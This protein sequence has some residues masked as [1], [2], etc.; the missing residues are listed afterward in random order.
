MISKLKVAITFLAA[1]IVTTQVPVPEQSP[2]Q[3]PKVKPAV[4]AAVRVTVV[5]L[6]RLAEQKVEGQFM[7]PTSLVTFPPPLTVTPKV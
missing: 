7:P 4:A 1:D 3:P 6:L 2:D 5:P